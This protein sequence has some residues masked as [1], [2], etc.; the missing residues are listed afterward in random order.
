MKKILSV[1]QLG[2]PQTETNPLYDSIEFIGGDFAKAKGKYTFICDRAFTYA[3]AHGFLLALDS[4]NADAVIFNGGCCFK[5]AV[6][7]AVAAKSGKKELTEIYA[8]LL[9]KS[10]ARSDIKPFTYAKKAL[11][12]ADG[13]DNEILKSVDE[14]NKSKARLPKE[15]YTFA[16]DLIC[17]ELNR[18]YISAVYALYKRKLSA[19]TLLDFDGRLKENIVLYLAMEKR[20]TAGDLKKLRSKGFKIPFFTANK[21][22]KLLIT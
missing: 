17:A 11:E 10:V 7:K 14:F 16:F 19:Q 1:L 20:F 3:D 9:C 2:L 5:T 22:K 8:A 18:F 13:T 6:I 4:F 15:V 12:Y 21:F